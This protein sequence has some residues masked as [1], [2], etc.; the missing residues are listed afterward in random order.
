MGIPR[1]LFAVPFLLSFGIK[2]STAQA[3]SPTSFWDHNNSL[4]ALYAS[5]DARIFRYEKPRDQIRQEGVQKGTILFTGTKDGDRYQ[6]TAYIFHR[7]C[8]PIAYP[9]NGT[10]SDDSRHV[11]LSGSAPSSLDSNCQ[12]IEFRNDV[13]EFKFIRA[14]T[15]G[16]TS[17]EPVGRATEKHVREQICAPTIRQALSASPKGQTE[18]LERT[19]IP[20]CEQCFAKRLAKGLSGEQRTA[21]DLVVT[22]RTDTLTPKTIQETSDGYDLVFD[23]CSKELLAKADDQ[24]SALPAKPVPTQKKRVH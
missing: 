17:S 4:M 22:G 15:N 23:A 19:L 20:L 1:F 2:L 11:T 14:L 3:E 9:V 6:G 10:V 13:L 16:A 24:L 12:P 5:G 21:L 7:N 18:I 8:D